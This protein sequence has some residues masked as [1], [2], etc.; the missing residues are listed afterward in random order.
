MTF[1]HNAMRLSPFLLT[2]LFGVSM[3]RH[4]VADQPISQRE[5]VVLAE[6]PR[7]SIAPGEVTVDGVA[8]PD[9]GQALADSMSAGLLKRGQVRIYNL[10]SAALADGA[11]LGS[12]S[13]T[14]SNHVGRMLDRDVDYLLT[15]NLL[16][17]GNNYLMT[18]KKTRAH[19][20]EVVEA[21]QFTVVGRFG[22]FFNM[23]GAILERIDPRPIK[24]GRHAF[25]RTQSPA[26]LAPL[27]PTVLV[28]G[29]AVP[30]DPWN[31][32]SAPPRYDLKNIPKALIYRRV[33][34]IGYVNNDWRFCVVKP[35]AGTQLRENDPLHVLYDEGDI[36]AHLR[37]CAV[38][39]QS[40]VADL[41]FTPSHHPLF[42]GDEVFG[43]APPLAYPVFK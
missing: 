34:S 18:I 15:F 24:P 8:R 39:R 38:D 7:L 4:G 16:G 21:H 23:M 19:T 29:S 43:W 22:G 42:K 9:L 36:Y 11:M 13:P 14:N 26:E 6:R 3:V 1:K 10:D 30:H 41:G 25:P 12:R 37:V 28:K 5:T 17:E 35:A 31:V 40:V 2:V 27:P 20:H 33:G 32:R